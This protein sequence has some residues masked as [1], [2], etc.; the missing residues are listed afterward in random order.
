M[1]RP[2]DK[3]L[4]L[5]VQV[6]NS[7]LGHLEFVSVAIVCLRDGVPHDIGS[8]T[9]IE[10]A[11][12]YFVATAHHV[13]ASYADDELFLVLQHE[14][15]DWTPIILGRGGDETLD[16][17]WLELPAEI[18]GAGIDRRF[19]PHTRLLPDCGHVTDD[20]AVVHGFPRDLLEPQKGTRGLSVQPLCYGTSTLDVGSIPDGIAD[21]DLY[22]GYPYGPVT[23]S[24]GKPAVPIEA[25]GLSGGGIWLVDAN[26]PGVWSAESCRLIG[27]Q[28]SWMRWK[29]VRGTQIQHWMA[30]VARDLPELA[31]VL[32]RELVVR[33]DLT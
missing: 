19:I 10:I 3:Q 8:G 28:H 7:V 33:E 13:I 23:G 16:V 30:L 20:V 31:P 18:V 4:K 29:W 5:F 9:C 11:G 1:T 14:A 27:I 17:A 22:L 25:P 2:T 15:Q 24:D 12:R 21:R 6:N 26:K 32:G